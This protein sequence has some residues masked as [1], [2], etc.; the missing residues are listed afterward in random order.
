MA[1]TIKM[2]NIYARELTDKEKEKLKAKMPKIKKTKKEK[3]R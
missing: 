1:K 2:K 3:K